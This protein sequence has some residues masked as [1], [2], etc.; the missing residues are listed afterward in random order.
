MATI[1]YLVFTDINGNEF[2]DPSAKGPSQFYV[3]Q[4]GDSLMITGKSV[5]SFGSNELGSIQCVNGG[6][7]STGITNTTLTDSTANFGAVDSLV[8]SK[9][10]PDLPNL[11]GFKI[12][13]NTATTITVSGG[14][15]A[16]HT[17]GDR[18]DFFTGVSPTGPC[19][20]GDSTDF[21]FGGSS[22]QGHHSIV[23]GS[24]FN[25]IKQ[26]QIH[27]A[28]GQSALSPGTKI[29]VT[30]PHATEGPDVYMQAF[31]TFF[32]FMKKFTGET[33]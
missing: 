21:P 4:P 14:L 5:F 11:T 26:A 18:Y 19:H 29:T 24:S 13:G 1:H 12:T 23:R 9:L 28:P 27:G 10:A 8:D 2:Q 3:P 33:S 25:G 17:V 31:G 30:G 6:G 22:A 20:G 15:T 16:V 32:F 7:T